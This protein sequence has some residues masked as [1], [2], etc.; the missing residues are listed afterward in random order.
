MQAG[1]TDKLAGDRTFTPIGMERLLCGNA[2]DR[3]LHLKKLTVI[4]LQCP[5]P[6][7]G[8]GTVVEQM[9]MDSSLVCRGGLGGFL[10]D[11]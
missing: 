8:T 1:G 10:W 9:I 5:P 3:K 11:T 6:A 7:S 2:E 4:M